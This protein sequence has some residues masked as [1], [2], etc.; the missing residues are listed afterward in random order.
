MWPWGESGSEDVLLKLSYTAPF[1]RHDWVIDR[2][3]THVRYVIDFYS[4]KADPKNPR[5]AA[6]YL[7][8]R[9]ALDDLT[10]VE[11]RVKGWWRQAVGS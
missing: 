5:N 7:D 3:G 1:D 2:C 9:P 4:G 10:G 8:V 11:T 6:F